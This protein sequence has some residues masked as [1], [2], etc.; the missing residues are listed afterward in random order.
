MTAAQLTEFQSGLDLF[1]SGEFYDCHE[2]L[3]EL[4]GDL[5]G[6]EKLLVQGL[7]QAAVGF[8]HLRTANLPGARSLFRKA[9][10][11]MDPLVKPFSF[12]IDIS[13]LMK[14]IRHISQKLDRV[15]ELDENLINIAAPILKMQQS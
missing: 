10:Q 4:W 9:I 14:S 6:E 7:I 2:V 5:H 12:L 13:P 15:S 8:Y 11:K 3:E 1:N